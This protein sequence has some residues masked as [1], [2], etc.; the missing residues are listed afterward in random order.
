MKE[1][2]LPALEAIQFDTSKEKAFGGAQEWYSTEWQQKAGCGPTTS[3]NMLVYLA[4]TKPYLEGL[5]SESILTQEQMVQA[6]EIIWN[7]VT[8][9]PRGVYKLEFLANGVCEYT[10]SKGIPFYPSLFSVS[11]TKRPKLETSQQFLYDCLSRGFPVPFLNLSSGREKKLYSWHWVLIV[12]IQWDEKNLFAT[13][14]DEGECINVN[15][16][17]WQRTTMLGGGYVGFSAAAPSA[18]LKR[19]AQSKQTTTNQPAY[20][21]EHNKS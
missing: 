1:L 21:D 3:A 13:L 15:L 16:D 12:G 20:S 17:L 10:Q 4:K 14:Y 11:V 18:T 7:Y 6:M 9:T 8:P 19:D 2:I 5:F